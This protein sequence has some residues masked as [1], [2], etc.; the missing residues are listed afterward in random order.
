ME[1]E[2]LEPAVYAVEMYKQED[3]QRRRSGTFA[4]VGVLCALIGGGS[5]F[6]A[7]KYAPEWFQSAPPLAINLPDPNV[8]SPENTNAGL[9]SEPSDLTKPIE[10]PVVPGET[11]PGAKPTENPPSSLGE[12]GMPP[13]NP[14]SGAII[15]DTPVPDGWKPGDPLPSTPPPNLTSDNPPAEPKV[16]EANLITARVGGGDPESEANEIA[17][18]LRGLGASVRLAPHYSLG[19]SVVGVQIIGTIPAKSV[20]GLMA[21]MGGGDNWKGALS[22]RNNRAEGML[23]SR[24]KDLQAKEAQL[25]EKYVEDATEVTVVK[26]EIQKLNQGLS[27]VRSAKSSGVAIIVIGIGSL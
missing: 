24:I 21:K 10:E 16:E 17:S 6:A 23:A 9:Y 5:V 14:L 3:R 7:F 2:P 15:G 1:N 11:K 27:L 18:G 22:D 25:K 4:I 13:F 8:K 20:K 12:G 19:G 26:E